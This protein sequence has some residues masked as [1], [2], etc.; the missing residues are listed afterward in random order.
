M[1]FEIFEQLAHLFK[2]CKAT[3]LKNVVHGPLGVPK[4]LSGGQIEKFG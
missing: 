4:M 1:Q 3:V 2:C